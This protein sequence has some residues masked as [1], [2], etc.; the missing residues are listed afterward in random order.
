MSLWNRFIAI[1]GITVLIS[2]ATVTKNKYVRELHQTA[3][4]SFIFFKKRTVSYFGS[5]SFI[6]SFWLLVYW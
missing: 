3:N 6:S 2:F 4:N 5:V 1:V